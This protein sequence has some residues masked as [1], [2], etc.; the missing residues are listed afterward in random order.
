MILKPRQYSILLVVLVIIHGA[1]GKSNTLTN[2]P[3][4][5]NKRIYQINIDFTIDYLYNG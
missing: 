4:T 2:L 3:F 1:K 5:F